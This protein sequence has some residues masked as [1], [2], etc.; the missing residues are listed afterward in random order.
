MLFRDIYLAF[1]RVL[2]YFLH[3]FTVFV[4][5]FY[6]TLYYMHA[7]IKE[8]TYLLS[9]DSTMCQYLAFH[10]SLL[11]NYLLWSPYGTGQTIIFSSSGF[12]LLLLLFFPCLISAAAHW[13]STILPHMVWP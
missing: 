2:L 10:V 12:Y 8:T 13:M 6:L 5:N 4:V 7:L 3:H 9:T 11:L 1:I